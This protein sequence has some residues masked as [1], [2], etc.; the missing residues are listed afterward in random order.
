[1][2]AAYGRSTATFTDAAT[3]TFDSSTAT[4]TDASKNHPVLIT[5]FSYE[6]HTGLVPLLSSVPAEAVHIAVRTLQSTAITYTC[7]PAI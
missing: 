5:A 2:S 1:M 7:I 4:I 6:Q 3:N